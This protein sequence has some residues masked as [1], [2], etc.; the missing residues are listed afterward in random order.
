MGALNWRHFEF[1]KKSVCL[2]QADLCG[3]KKIP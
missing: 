1:L 2:A 3:R